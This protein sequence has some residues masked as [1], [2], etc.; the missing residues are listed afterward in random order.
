MEYKIIVSKSP[1]K[2]RLG[3]SDIGLNNNCIF[4]FHTNANYLGI[5]SGQVLSSDKQIDM[6]KIKY[7]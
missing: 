1:W 6:L 7:S 4:K 5:F 2:Q 3:E